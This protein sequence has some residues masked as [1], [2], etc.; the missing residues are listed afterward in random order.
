MRALGL[1]S[2]VEAKLILDEI[3]AKEVELS[4]HLLD[5]PLLT[6]RLRRK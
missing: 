1:V 2:R 4:P 6:L 3:L 5:K